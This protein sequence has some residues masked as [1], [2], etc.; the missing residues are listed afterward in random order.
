MSYY[1]SRDGTLL[2][3]SPSS[4]LRRSRRS[5]PGRRLQLVD[6]EVFSA[7]SR[8]NPVY[9]MDRVFAPPN[10]ASKP[11]YARYIPKALAADPS[12]RLC[13][14]YFGK[15]YTDETPRFVNTN[16]PLDVGRFNMLR[17]DNEDLSPTPRTRSNI[18]CLQRRVSVGLPADRR[19]SEMIAD[20]FLATVEAQQSMGDQRPVDTRI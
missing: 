7:L 20:T 16:F 12:L 11:I 18:L 10:K 6:A 4:E 14:L 9:A 2:H 17:H 5:T 13:R 15:T 3:M 1:D 19:L 8:P